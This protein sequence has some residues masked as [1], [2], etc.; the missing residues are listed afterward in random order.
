M[1]NQEAIIIGVQKWIENNSAAVQ[2]AITQGVENAM[3]Q[4]AAEVGVRMAA[5]L[6]KFMAENKDD[7]VKVGKEMTEKVVM[8]QIL[9]HID[10]RY[11]AIPMSQVKSEQ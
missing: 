7:F 8:D 9:E 10:L 6:G 11:P 5:R 3:P 4:I 2:K 1:N